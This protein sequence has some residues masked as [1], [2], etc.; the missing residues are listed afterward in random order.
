MDFRE[1][2]SLEVRRNEATRIREKFPGR[3]PCI[4]QRAKN[5]VK[6]LP[7]IDKEKFLVP[8]DL[9]LGQFIFVVRKRI[10]LESNKAL[11]VFVGNTLPTTGSLM[12]ELYHS[13]GEDDGF[14]YLLYC[15]ESTFG[16]GLRPL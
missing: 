11:F 16:R 6:T 15:G 13:H 4:V 3:V 1:R 2:Y 5:A 14:L 9:T 8:G 7:P 10:E 12:R